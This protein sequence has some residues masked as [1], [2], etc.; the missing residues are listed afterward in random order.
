MPLVSN[1]F[2]DNDDLQDCLVDDASHVTP[3]QSGDHV[4]LIQQALM[5]LG[6]GTISSSELASTFY[7]T[8]TANAVLGYKTRYGIINRSYQQ[9]PDNIVGKMTISRLDNDMWNHEQK[10]FSNLVSPTKRG[11]PEHNHSACVIS[12]DQHDGTPINPLGFGRMINIWGSGETTYLGFKDYAIDP[13]H[14]AGRPLT[15]THHLWGGVRDHSASDIFM[16]NSPVYDDADLKRGFI[17][18]RSTTAEIKRMAMPGCRLTYTGSTENMNQF[19]H[20]VRLL[21][22][23]METNYVDRDGNLFPLGFKPAEKDIAYVVHILTL[24]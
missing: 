6:E 17:S 20:K 3:G 10:P 1:H 16:R 18:P 12:Y 9:T 4:E 5:L 23:L 13:K 11:T 14:A 15:W 24:L 2:K 8:S 19:F 22:V 21:G 7:G